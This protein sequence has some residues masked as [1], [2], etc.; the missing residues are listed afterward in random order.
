M[1][2]KLA[3]VALKAFFRLRRQNDRPALL[4][5]LRELMA[6]IMAAATPA[7]REHVADMLTGPAP[8][9]VEWLGQHG[10]RWVLVNW[11][12][13]RGAPLARSRAT[14]IVERM[15]FDAAVPMRLLEAGI[16]VSA[17][18]AGN[19]D[20]A[21]IQ[22]SYDKARLKEI[23]MG[24]KV[25]FVFDPRG[26]PAGFDQN[27]FVA[28]V[29]D[30][31]GN[32]FGLPGLGNEN[33]YAA[34]VGI[35]LLNEQTDHGAVTFRDAV[36]EAWNETLAEVTQSPGQPKVSSRVA[37]ETIA[38]K[39]ADPTLNLVP[40][41]AAGIP[42][43]SYQQFA[44]VARFVIAKSDDVFLVHPNIAAQVRIGLDQYI[45][46]PPLFEVLDLPPLGDDAQIVDDNVRSVGILAACYFLERTR[47]L[48]VLD[49]IT[50]EFM[51][52]KVPI[53]FDAA[54]RAL[55]E[56]RTIPRERLLSPVER[57]AVYS[58]VLGFA[59]GDVPKDVIPNKEW[60][61]NLDR[62]IAAVAEYDRQ[63]RVA[64]FFNN[65][66][67]NQRPLS[68]TGE[69]V[70]K[71]ANDLGRISSLYGYAGTQF[72]ARRIA[73]MVQRALRILTIPSLQRAY[74]VTNPY[75]LIER[76]AASNLGQS[77]NVVKY[78]TMAESVKGIMD[79]I[80]RYAPVWSRTGG[81][82]LFS[83]DIAP[84]P[85]VVLVGAAVIPARADIADRDRDALITQV[86][87]WL[88]VTGTGDQ[89]IEK[90][91][92]PSPSLTAPSIPQLYGGGNGSAAVDASA[93]DKIRQLVSGGSAPSLEQLQSLLP[94]MRA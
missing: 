14:A 42:E 93:I 91:S 37:Y 21:L 65:A 38:T 20:E 83:D 75:Q 89:Q 15:I 4:A 17:A 49:A 30:L 82:P 69:L 73:E 67:G 2:E 23:V 19:G 16:R 79:V 32:T 87:Y 46:G 7:E 11:A 53:G 45:S 40:R 29:A 43:I 44:S 68:Y 18:R 12:M 34:I 64:L 24:Q 33:T 47:L 57:S 50:G 54:G 74:G 5:K 28:R 78:K 76:V 35:L 25:S 59:G 85:P 62:F 72:D 86:Q 60:S 10:G 27:G 56:Y 36:G 58:R 9:L 61:S 92:Q 26:L 55:D 51:V 3:L 88:A 31:L 13:A 39:L 6:G 52:G 48:D 84:A 81:T 70:R 80:A 90:L 66:A 71:A 77:V 94:A 8:E 22:R 1:N 41:D 63:R